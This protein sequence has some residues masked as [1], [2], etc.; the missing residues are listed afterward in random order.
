MFAINK[1]KDKLTVALL[2]LLTKVTIAWSAETLTIGTFQGAPETTVKVPVVIQSATNIGSALIQ[3]NYDPTLLRFLRATNTAGT[4]GD[5]YIMGYGDD[6]QSVRIVMA[7]DSG[8][9]SQAGT[10][11]D[12]FF[13]VNSGALPGMFSPLIIAQRKLGGVDGSNLEDSQNITHSNGTLWVAFSSLDDSD[14]DGLSD[15]QE[16]MLNGSPDY[17]PGGGD[18]DVSNP[19]TDGDGMLDGWE[20]MHGLQPL[21]NDATLDKDGDGMSNY[22]EW[23]VGSNPD[24]SSSTFKVSLAVQNTFSNSFVLSWDAF[25]GNFYSVYSKSNLMDSVWF[26]NLFRRPCEFTGTMSYTNSLAPASQFFRIGTERP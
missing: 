15:Y 19:D 21:T 13:N 7:C 4:V 12:L 23:L 22:A 20:V 17:L 2:F 25:P 11:V 9:C 5:K 14:N 8:T 26:T 18:T 10:L 3:I 16:Q 24:D 1:M 6:G